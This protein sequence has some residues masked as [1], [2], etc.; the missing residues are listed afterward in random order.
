M[1]SELY[2]SSRCAAMRTRD[3][4]RVETWTDAAN[5]R[6]AWTDWLR[7]S[8]SREGVRCWLGSSLAMPFMLEPVPGVRNWAELEAVAKA[9]A[10]DRTDMPGPSGVWIEAWPRQHAALCVAYDLQMWEAL[11]G[12]LGPRLL[13]LRPWWSDVITSRDGNGEQAV[14]IEEPDAFVLL[15]SEDERICVANGY[16]VNA[17][18]PPEEVRRRVMTAAGVSGDQ[19]A[20]LRMTTFAHTE[21]SEEP[22]RPLLDW[23]EEWQPS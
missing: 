4:V 3:G 21:V 7:E 1:T 18:S 15:G 19:C 14:L 17:L 10:A 20:L 9:V 23:V 8:D 16:S 5:R 6:P 13:S 2:V 12:A 22:S 11:T